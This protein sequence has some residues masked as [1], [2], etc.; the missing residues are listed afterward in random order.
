MTEQGSQAYWVF[1]IERGHHVT[2]RRL[3][4]T[5]ARQGGVGV[6]SASDRVE[7]VASLNVIIDAGFDF[8]Y[9]KPSSED[10]NL[11]P[12]MRRAAES[13]VR[14]MRKAIHAVVQRVFKK[15]SHND[16]ILMA[17]YLDSMALADTE[18]GQEFIGFPLNESLHNQLRSGMERI[19]TE[20]DIAAYSN[21]LINLFSE[22]VR[23]SVH[24]YCFLPT[25]RVNI[26]GLSK[27][28]ADLGMDAVVKAI[29]GLIRRLLKDIAHD[30]I[31]ELPQNIAD[32]VVHLDLPYK[33]CT[34]EFIQSKGT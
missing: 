15:L 11:S 33:A 1:P 19:R 21:D 10:D 14:T 4:M 24:Y 31:K 13:V 12:M 23:E 7:L 3:A 25:S 32:V 34:T 6:S 18:N 8:Y 26:G 20:T 22:I 2:I 27:K 17:F 5:L 9:Q 29:N 28:A 16:L 30:D